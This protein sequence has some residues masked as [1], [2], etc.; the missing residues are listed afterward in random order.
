[1]A[2]F[3]KQSKQKNK[4]YLSICESYYDPDKKGTAQKR[5]KSYGSY[6]SLKAGGIDDPIAYLQKEVEIL[7]LMREN[8]HQKKISDKSIS[9]YLGYFPLKSIMEKLD[10]KKTI[11]ILSRYSGFEFDLYELTTSLVYARCVCPCSKYKTFHDVLPSLYENCNFSYDQLLS[12]LE[13]L[14]NNY[15]KFIELF[16]RQLSVKFGINANLTYFD[17]TNFYFEIDREDDFRRKGP[18]KENKKSPIVG[19]GLLLDFNQ[20]PINMKLY[21]GNESE[22]PIIRDVIAGI[23][24]ENNI[25]GRIIHVADKGLNCGENIVFAKKNQDGYIFSKTVK[26]LSEHEKEWV[27]LESGFKTKRD[28]DGKILYRY[29][30]CV[31]KFPY[32]IKLG[33]KQLKLN[34]QKKDY[35]HI[36]QT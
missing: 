1:M 32:T 19:L 8:A 33:I 15:Q 9:L 24:K 25:T 16:T 35:L 11:D 4:V 21:P 5:F 7:N 26:G 36:I 23:K 12:G 18:S 34:L 3:V 31:D 30:S 2:Y 22:K 20:I 13:Y 10:V 29:K 28:R 6:E 17:C 14:G 27:L